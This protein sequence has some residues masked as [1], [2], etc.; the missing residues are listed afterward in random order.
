MIVDSGVEAEM[1]LR[2]VTQVTHFTSS[3]NLPRIFEAGEI[4]ATKTL[5]SQ[6]AVFERTDAERLDGYLEHICCNLEYPNHYYFARATEKPNAVNYS[7]WS[8]FL[9]DPGVAAR[10]GTLFSPGNAA[11]NRGGDAREGVEALRRIY[12]PQVYDWKRAASH[13]PSSPTDV[14]AEIL[15]PGPID[16]SLVRGIVVPDSET[17]G[18]EQGRLAQ[19]GHDVSTVP[20][21][22]SAGM[23]ERSSVVRAIRQNVD[24]EIETATEGRS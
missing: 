5:E 17:L 13:R 4:R 9:L 16:L 21:F 19:I 15:V 1:R 24:I 11:K 20:W 14:Q 18:R 12:E 10:V 23:F 22:V 3:R 6:G 8:L 7:D 2:G